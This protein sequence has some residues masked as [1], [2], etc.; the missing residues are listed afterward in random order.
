M[1]ETPGAATKRVEEHVPAERQLADERTVLLDD[2]LQRVGSELPVP[3]AEF[4]EIREHVRRPADR[5]FVL[6]DSPGHDWGIDENI[7]VGAAIVVRLAVGS[8]VERCDRVLPHRREIETHLVR[9]FGMLGQG[10][11]G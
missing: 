3:R 5:E 7:V 4:S 11:V 2:A 1:F 10:D 8:R 6:A 9:P